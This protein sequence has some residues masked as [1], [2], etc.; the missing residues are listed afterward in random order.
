MQIANPIYDTVFKYLMSDSK[1]AKAL[2]S[3]IIGEQIEELNFAPHEYILKKDVDKSKID[4]TL[5]QITIFRIDFGAKIK[6]DD[7]YKTVLIELQKAKLATDIM[8]FRRYLGEMYEN[9]ENSY[10]DKREKARQIYCIYFLNYEIG[11]SDS[12]VIKV[13]YKVSD[14]TTGEVFEKKNEFIESLNH[15]SWIIQVRQLKARR[16]NELEN[17]LSIFDQDNITNN[18]HILNID[19]NQF[20]EEYGFITRKLREAFESKQVREEMHIEDEFLN[21][22][23]NL[24]K[25][26]ENLA[27]ELTKKDEELTKKDEELTKKDEEL[28]KKDEEI[29]KLREQ[30]KKYTNN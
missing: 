18:K 7:G 11:L 16:R 1:V 13:D 10:D 17:L 29:K 15:R 4:R 5:E 25:S 6:T 28:T 20:P 22:L 9:Q 27:I 26:N 2:L 14:M 30:L 3:A 12:P 8:R 19:E 24:Q 21:E 23:L